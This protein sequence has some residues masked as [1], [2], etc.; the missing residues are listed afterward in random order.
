[1]WCSYLVGLDAQVAALR[2]LLRVV[3]LGSAVLDALVVVI[4]V[5]VLEEYRVAPRCSGLEGQRVVLEEEGRDRVAVEVG[6]VGS[7]LGDAGE[8]E[9]G[10]RD[11]NVH[12]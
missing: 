10:R 8:L 7:D 5:V 9:D 2:L 6:E 4:D 3:V 11:V 1:M 12:D